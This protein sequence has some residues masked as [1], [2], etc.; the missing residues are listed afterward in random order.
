MIRI[1]LFI[2]NLFMVMHIC[3][4][5]KSISIGEITGLGSRFQI[6]ETLPTGGQIPVFRNRT[7]AL[8]WKLSRLWNALGRK[9]K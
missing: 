5:I 4:K 9:Q 7:V 3:S 8:K 6:L 1:Y 2:H